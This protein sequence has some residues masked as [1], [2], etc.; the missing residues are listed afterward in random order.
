[1]RSFFFNDR[2]ECFPMSQFISRVVRSS[3]LHLLLAVFIVEHE[4][5]APRQWGWSAGGT[6][7]ESLSIF[8]VYSSL[9]C[10]ENCG[11]EQVPMLLL[12]GLDVITTLQFI[13]K[14][15]FILFSLD[16]CSRA[17]LL[18]CSKSC[19]VTTLYKCL[20]N[21]RVSSRWELPNGRHLYRFSGMFGVAVGW[22][23]RVYLVCQASFAF[24]LAI[25]IRSVANI[26]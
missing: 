5:C 9:N 12:N 23:A 16:A 1:M 4:T 7:V 14:S 2:E 26:V 11:I 8:D 10:V 15:C 6:V 25:C 24:Y 22:V 3:C 20:T 19:R 13:R 17:F 21:P 18:G